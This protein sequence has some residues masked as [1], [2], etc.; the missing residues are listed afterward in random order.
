M[1]PL[2]SNQRPPMNDQQARQLQ[3]IQARLA[4]EYPEL[5]AI[6]LF[7]SWA[8]EH[9]RDDSD[10][11]IAI[12][13]PPNAG[14]KKTLDWYCLASELAELAGTEKA[15]LIDLRKANTILQM[16]I[17]DSGQ[18][19]YAADAADAFELLTLAKYQKLTEERRDIVNDGINSGHFYHG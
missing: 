14:N 13:L 8:G 17:L 1:Y 15:D 6:Y 2:I 19:H 10:L 9:Q 12:L 5:E 16:E 3:A 18:R 4:S 7:G 11:D